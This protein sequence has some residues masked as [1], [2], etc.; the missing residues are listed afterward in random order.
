MDEPGPALADGGDGAGIGGCE[1]GHTKAGDEVN[2][3]GQPGKYA[4]VEQVEEARMRG[5]LEAHLMT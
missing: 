2:P 5:D 4:G 3:C 1:A